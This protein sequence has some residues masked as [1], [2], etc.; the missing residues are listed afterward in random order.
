[1]ISRL[2]YK[3]RQP[4]HPQSKSEPPQALGGRSAVFRIGRASLPRH[5]ND[6]LRPI[7]RLWNRHIGKRFR[8]S[9]RNGIIDRSGSA[10]FRVLRPPC[11]SMWGFP[12]D[13]GRNRSRASLLCISRTGVLMNLLRNS[14]DRINA[15]L[16]EFPPSNHPTPKEDASL[17]APA[18]TR[19]RARRLSRTINSQ[20]NHRFLQSKQVT[21]EVQ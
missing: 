16:G 10:L 19:F 17:G 15:L 11:A 2:R 9:T 21:Q 7:R 18:S 3:N 5:K 14:F 12:L 1:M 8:S 20:K 4:A 13:S 6:R